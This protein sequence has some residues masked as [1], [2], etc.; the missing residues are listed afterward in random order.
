MTNLMDAAEAARESARPMPG[1]SAPYRAA[2]NALLAEEIELRRHKER[3]AAMRRALPEGPVAP[4]YRFLDAEGREVGLAD[5]FG[6]RDALF[7]YFWMAGPERERPCPMC[8]GFL[9]TF[10]ASAPA[11]EERVAFAVLGRSPVSRQ[12]Q[13]ARERGW[14][15]LRFFQVASEDFVADHGLIQPDF[16]EVPFDAVWTRAD[17]VVRRFWSDEMSIADPGQDPR[18]VLDPTPLWAILDLTP[19]GRG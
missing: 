9:D 8:Q 11:I 16:G 6:D 5:L 3:V 2:R 15:N 12:L 4:D 14:R 10:D 19:G 18:G 1:E 7:T 13:W 17:G